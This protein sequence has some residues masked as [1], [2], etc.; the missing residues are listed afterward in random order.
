MFYRG[1]T[2]HFS[3]TFK[4]DAGDPMAP[5]SAKVNVRYRSDDDASYDD[6]LLDLEDAGGG[7]W[8]VTWDSSVA[9]PGPVY[10]SARATDGTEVIVKDGSFVLAANQA[11]PA[12]S[13]SP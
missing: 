11:N 13:D 12:V 5:N 2:I 1:A 7:M 9:R 4:D 8:R 3:S 10:W 6:E